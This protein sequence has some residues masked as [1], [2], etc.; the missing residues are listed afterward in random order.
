MK[1]SMWW[2]SHSPLISHI[3]MLWKWIFEFVASLFM[4]YFK[5]S[6][7]YSRSSFSCCVQLP[8]PR[9]WKRS[10]SKSSKKRKKKIWRMKNCKPPHLHLVFLNEC[11][12][13]ISLYSQTNRHESLKSEFFSII[14]S[15]L[16]STFTMS[17]N[18]IEIFTQEEI[19]ILNRNAI[20]RNFTVRNWVE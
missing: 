8:S 12:P 18:I 2:L 14:L 3:I 4:F 6:S 16:V 13:C 10:W 15:S 19:D 11:K 9:S 17:K 7:F 1:N 5:S 20:E